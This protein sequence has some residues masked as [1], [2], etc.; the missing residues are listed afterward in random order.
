[1]DQRIVHEVD[2]MDELPGKG[3][4]RALGSSPV[5]ALVVVHQKP[6][7]DGLCHAL[8]RDSLVARAC[9]DEEA[10]AVLAE[11]RPHLLIV[12]L[13]DGGDQLLARLNAAGRLLERTSVIAVTRRNDLATK[14]AAFERGVDDVVSVPVSPEELA[15]RAA[16]IVRRARRQAVT[17]TTLLRFGELE[18]DILRRRAWVGT[19]ELRLTSVEQSLLTLLVAN[20]GRLLSRDE[21]L[22]QLWGD[23]YATDSNV[24]DRHVRNLRAKL[25]DDWRAPL[26]IATVPGLGYRFE[27]GRQ[28]SADGASSDPRGGAEPL[29]LTAAERAALE[30]AAATEGRVREWRRYRAV[31]LAAEE[32]PEAAVRALGCARSSVYAW[33]AAWRRGGLG[34]VAERPRRGGRP[35]LLARGGTALLARLLAEDPRA[36]DRR[37]TGWTVALLRAE[38]ARAGY[39]AG[40]QTVRRALHQLG[41][42]WQR[43]TF[44]QRPPATA[45]AHE[46]QPSRSARRRA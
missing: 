17:F 40:D 45:P 14:L 38:L 31:L 36:R 5:R 30:R 12:D 7:G 43:P 15:A 10:P 42:A 23:D 29:V 2:L 11:W 46:A 1:M 22:D 13:D 26:Y 33:L 35:S 9:H 41:W 32:G 21:I 20:A 37:A 24:V 44:V 3:H 39:P 28:N 34:G 4:A 6:L 8:G 27:A 16:A 19:T 25:Q 18:I